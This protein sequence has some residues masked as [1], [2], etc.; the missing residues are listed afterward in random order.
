MPE[1]A[2][3]G[4]FEPIARPG[5]FV[6]F[7]DVSDGTIYAVT[8][9]NVL[10]EI[11]LESNFSPSD[12]GIE[13][14]EL[15][16][17]EMDEGYLAQYRLLKLPE[18]LPDD[19]EIR[20]DHD[21]KQSPLYQTENVRGVLTNETGAVFTDD[22]AGGAAVDRHM[23]RF[24]ELFVWEDNPPYFTVENNTGGA[25]DIPLT[26]TGYAFKLEEVASGLNDF[27]SPQPV[28]IPRRSVQF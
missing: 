10:P 9:Y 8:A 5:G 11:Q 25:V 17:I 14:R 15:T 18:E 20:V 27:D 13:K 26:F 6:Q 21:G 24:T 23:S 2:F 1:G 19:V 3:N 16:D 22:T 28:V 4:G 7:D 12:G